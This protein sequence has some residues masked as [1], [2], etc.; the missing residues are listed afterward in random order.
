MSR[1]SMPAA[2]SVSSRLG[3]G[4]GVGVERLTRGGAF[5]GDARGDVGGIGGGGDL[6]LAGDRQCAHDILRGKSRRGKRGGEH[7]GDE[8]G[9]WAHYWLL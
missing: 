2:F 5:G 3:H 7:Q 9:E 4:G 6:A 1:A 8:D